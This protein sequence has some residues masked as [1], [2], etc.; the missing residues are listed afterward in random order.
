MVHIK[1]CRFDFL[2]ESRNERLLLGG[3]FW[4]KGCMSAPACNK[5]KQEPGHLGDSWCLCCSA[6]EAISGELRA[7]WAGSGA[8]QVAADILSSAVRQIRALR[9][10]GV[11]SAGVSRGQRDSA[12]FRRAESA[13]PGEVP[14]P[15]ERPVAGEARERPRA[16]ESRVKEEDNEQA[17]SSDEE[18]EESEDEEDEAPVVAAAAKKK[19]SS[20]ERSPVRR[21]PP[22][23]EPPSPPRDRHRRAHSRERSQRRDHSRDRGRSYEESSRHRDRADWQDRS[24]VPA[25]KKKKKKRKSKTGKTHRA[26]GKHQRLYRGEANPYQRLHYKPPGSYWDQ[27]PPRL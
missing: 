26:G 18:E 23:P 1:S 21:R 5:C 14:E 24:S 6:T 8:R 9:R 3:A 7:N 2:D 22:I 19:P 20:E 12:G 13:R 16:G 15:A 11:A 27:G 4:L 17:D 25:K 10:L